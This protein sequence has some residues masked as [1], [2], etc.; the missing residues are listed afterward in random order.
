MF[1]TAFAQS[2][3]PSGTEPKISLVPS[4]TASIDEVPQLFNILHG[5][6]SFVGPRPELP[7]LV[8]QYGPLHHLRHT[9][10]PGITG[11]WQVNGRCSRLDGCAVEDDL[12]VKLADDAYYLRHQSLRLD[13][14]I[15]LLTIP[16]IVRGHGSK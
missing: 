5:D 8:A 11:W 13:M 4:S 10:V 2:V 1:S 12:A 7:E 14:R 16:V 9:V 3:M 15:L 6:M